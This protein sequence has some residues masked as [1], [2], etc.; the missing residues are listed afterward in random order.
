MST[1]DTR[2]VSVRFDNRQFERGVAQTV[3]SL[4]E[5]QGGLDLDNSAKSLNNLNKVGQKFDLSDIS[6]GVGLISKRFTTLGIVGVTALQ[7]ITNSVVNTGRRMLSALT[8]DPIKTGLDEYETKINA[9]QTILT[10]T[11]S[12]GVELADVNRVLAELNEYADLTIYNFAE[13]T[14][15]IGTF[16]AAGVELDTAAT[17]IKGIANLAAASGS[18]AQQASTAMYQLS[19]AI[20]AGSVK[21]Q[22]WNS[23][24]NAGM[25][26]ELFQNAL[27]ES[28]K[29]MG[30]FV[31]AAEPFRETLRDGWLTS[32]VLTKTLSDF[33]EDEAL[34]KAATQVKTF[35]QLYDTMQ[36]AV[37]SGWAVSWEQIIGDKREATETLTAISDAFNALIEP[38]VEARNFMLSYWNALG[39]RQ[40]IIDALS[41]SFNG[42]KDAIAPIREAFSEVFPPMTGPQLVEISRG[43]KELSEN[44]KITDETANKIKRTF[45][46]LFSLVDTGKEAI[47]ALGKGLLNLIGPI[48]DIDLDILSVTASIGDYLIELNESIK[49]TGIFGKIVNGTVEGI[50][51]FGRWV[52]QLVFSFLELNGVDLTG[53]GGFLIAL[54]DNLIKGLNNLDMDLILSSLNSGLFVAITVGLK[55]FIDSLATISSSGSD[56]LEG[57]TGILD[58]V[59]GS[60]EAYQSQLK[61]NTLLKIAGAMG[62]LAAAIYLLSTI[63]PGK[64]AGA[65]GAMTAMFVELF[66]SMAVFN[67]IVSGG[68]FTAMGQITISMIALSTAVLIL[69]K[70]V[71]ELAAIDQEKMANGLLGVGVVLAEL[72]V[73]MRLADFGGMG[74]RVGLGLI[75]L[76]TAILILS[77]SVEVFASMDSSSLIKGLIALGVVLVEIAAFSALASGAKGMI[78]VAIGMTI[79]GAAMLIFAKAIETMG[80]LELQQIGKGLLAMAG[81]LIILGGAL[82]LIPKSTIILG[83]ALLI[84]AAALVKMGEAL[85]TMS[86]LSWDEIGRGLIGLLGVLGLISASM[87]IMRGSLGGAASLIVVTVALNGL[88]G[89][90]ERFGNMSL[91]EIGKGLLTM[92][93]ALGIIGAAGYI[94]APIVPAILA[95]GAGVALLGVGITA[96]GAGLL[97]FATALTALAVSGT[98]GVAALV[99]IISAVLSL[100]PIVFKKVGE[101]VIEFAK[102][103]EFGIPAIASALLAVGKAIIKVLVELIPDVTRGALELLSA[104]LQAFLDYMPNLMDV[105]GDLIIAFLQGI[106]DKAPGIIE[107]AIEIVIKFVDGVVSQLPVIIDA[108]FNLMIKFIEGMADASEKNAPLLVKA[109]LK[110]IGSLAK[111]I[112]N[113]VVVVTDAVDKLAEKAIEALRAKV[114]E[115]ID[116]GSEVVSGFVKGIKNKISDVADGV[117]DMA[118]GA[119]QSAK[120]ALDIH[121]PSKET[122]WL[123]VMFGRGMAQGIEKST[124]DVKKAAKK[125]SSEAYKEAKAWIDERKYYNELSLLEEL[126]AWQKVQVK[127]KADSEERK[128]IDREV[129]RVKKE[130]TGKMAKLDDEYTKKH[131]DTIKQWTQDVKDLN[132]AYDDAVDQRAQSIFD[133]FS[134]F[135]KIEDPEVAVEGTDLLQNLDSQVK[136]IKQWR[137][138]LD[139]LSEKGVTEDLLKELEELG[140]QSANEIKALN[141]LSRGQLEQYEDLW[142]EKHAQARNQAVTELE[143]M[144]NDNK[145]KLKLMY[146]DTLEELENIKTVWSEKMS[147]LNGDTDKSL[148]ELQTEWDLQITGLRETT[149]TEFTTMKDNVS[150]MDWVGLG[151]TLIANIK[152]GVET[153]A[154]NLIETMR[155]LAVNVYDAFADEISMRP[156]ITPVVDMAELQSAI[157]GNLSLNSPLDMLAMAGGIKI[158]GISELTSKIQ[159]LIDK[160]PTDGSGGVTY[161]FDIAEQV[162]REDTDVEKVA[163]E[164]ERMRLAG[165]RG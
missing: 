33:A 125:Q 79:L 130:L 162:I 66:G 160:L 20:A 117:K 101:A 2:I 155:Q 27:R 10:N 32:E 120:D 42:L 113:S 163:A 145:D 122:E 87:V 9:I 11:A 138:N 12:K 3:K 37:Q 57:V 19:Q 90:L 148:T 77:K 81:I 139:E 131:S 58:G 110:L 95:L 70:A 121:S 99:G 22:D 21:L 13:M 46:G 29:E 103:I 48:G 124:P 86:S 41:N 115:F 24:V 136:A 38:S 153:E 73:F 126:D 141:Q 118:V 8:I 133:A 76:A 28:A 123:G 83:P 98:A 94:L 40:D 51:N 85:K 1:V 92:A 59:K 61:A 112:I 54:Q 96:A 161:N 72:A 55:K 67:T 17:S 15:N 154:T 147:E 151:A 5:L 119:L 143:G 105:G 36:E 7:N 63:D 65:L 52:K 165:E 26:G 106:S 109:V 64:L 4:H 49:T 144:K 6:E 91:P 134:L 44:F 60:L 74:T 140:P 35:T 14:R 104:L 100:I 56:I 47:T 16:T 128:Q 89:V 137:K 152:S 50:K 45:K 71:T 108:G 114:G 158:D 84:V 39:G 53:A 135:S 18:N 156:L 142:G 111:A 69:S 107:L 88:A 78:T 129:Y 30:I 127:Y 164:M 23:V 93:A 62:I 102:A 68:G 146:N 159:K 132:T 97:L 75:A 149:E 25:G 80:D 34:V 43:L 116:V 157:D 150:G 82:R 31:D